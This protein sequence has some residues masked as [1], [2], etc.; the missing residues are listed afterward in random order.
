MSDVLVRIKRA[1]LA[2]HY[3]FS[4]KARDEMEADGITELDVA[5][6]ILNAVAIY[7]TLRSRSPRRRGAV[8]YLYVI[9]STNLDGL[10]IYT[11]GKLVRQTGAETYCFLISS[12]RVA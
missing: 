5:E 6:S 10:A 12:K 4:E 11:K 9:Q 7:K 2:G 8:E 3:A 1:I